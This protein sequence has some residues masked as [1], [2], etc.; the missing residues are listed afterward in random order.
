MCESEV[1]AAM[2]E[3]IN[4]TAARASFQDSQSYVIFYSQ[5]GVSTIRWDKIAF[6]VIK[7]LADFRV[8]W[9]KSYVSL[10]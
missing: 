9:K 1:K 2:T 6:L 3:I 10:V 7:G 8:S 4:G 5:N